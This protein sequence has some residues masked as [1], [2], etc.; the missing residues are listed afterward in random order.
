MRKV[1]V[2][3]GVVFLSALLGA[4]SLTE[5][6]MKNRKYLTIYAKD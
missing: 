2:I 5:Y 6:K 4:F 1:Y 3:W